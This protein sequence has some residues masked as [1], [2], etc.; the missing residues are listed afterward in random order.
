VYRQLQALTLKRAQ[1]L[2]VQFR[3]A[4]AGRLLHEDLPY[5]HTRTG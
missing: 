1:H 4:L 3:R 2:P 5:E